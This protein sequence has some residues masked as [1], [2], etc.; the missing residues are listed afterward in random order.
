[1]LLELFDYNGTVMLSVLVYLGII[2]LPPVGGLGTYRVGPMMPLFAVLVGAGDLMLTN[3][4]WTAL[5]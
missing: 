5:G 1:M 2:N 4:R 3:R